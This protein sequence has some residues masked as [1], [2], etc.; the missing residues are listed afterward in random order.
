MKLIIVLVLLYIPIQ[1]VGGSH[2]GSTSIFKGDRVGTETQFLNTVSA[3]RVEMVKQ[4]KAGGEVLFGDTDVYT[5]Y[6]IND[7][8]CFRRET[9]VTPFHLG[10]RC[11]STMVSERMPDAW[12]ESD[13]TRYDF[14]LIQGCAE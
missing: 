14:K 7:T 12:N 5:P 8:A 9:E 3:L 4:C 13:V 6:L 11:K 10:T 1:W 2:P